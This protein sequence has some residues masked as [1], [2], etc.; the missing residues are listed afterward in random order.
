MNKKLKKVFSCLLA[1]ALICQM[2]AFVVIAEPNTADIFRLEENFDEYADGTTA[3]SIAT[4]DS[5]WTYM[6]EKDR[7]AIVQNKALYMTG[8]PQS[9][10]QSGRVSFTTT[11]KFTDGYIQTDVKLDAPPN[12]TKTYYTGHILA[13]CTTHLVSEIGT[14]FSVRRNASGKII[15]ALELL[16][17]DP[18]AN[19]G[20]Y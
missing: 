3:D 20:P 18:N 6:H 19:S 16:V 17:R 4:A 8:Y 15:V 11:E 2:A 9:D 13:R 10:F 5:G 12:D 14:R 7:I 1:L